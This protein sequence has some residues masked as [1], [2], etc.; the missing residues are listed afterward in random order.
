[1]I[2]FGQSGFIRI[3]W[4]YSGKSGCIWAKVV[5]FGQKWFYSGKRGCIRA[6]VVLIGQSQCILANVVVFRVKWLYLGESE[7]IWAKVVDL[8]KKMFSS[9][10]GGSIRAKVVVFRQSCCKRVKVVVFMQ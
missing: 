7:S 4:L 6:K 2:V 10:K 5:L 3:N 9:D 8:G 1:M